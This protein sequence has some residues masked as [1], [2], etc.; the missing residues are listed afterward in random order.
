MDNNTLIWGAV[1]I[2]IL[3]LLAIVVPLALHKRGQE[4]PN[5]DRKN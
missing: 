1:G 5:G 4:S 3:C 2:S